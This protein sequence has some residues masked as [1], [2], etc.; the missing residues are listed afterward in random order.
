MKDTAQRS[1]LSIVFLALALVVIVACG[2]QVSSPSNSLTGRWISTDQIYYA[3]DGSIDPSQLKITLTYE[4]SEDGTFFRSHTIVH[5]DVIFR[6]TYS[7]I[8][9]KIVFD[10]L[11]QEV[12]EEIRDNLSHITQY[13][14]EFV[15]SAD[16]LTLTTPSSEQFS[17]IETLYDKVQ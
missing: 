12:P 6:G 13:E 11:E 17:K 7:V 3:L 14:N 9:N 16:T 4:F 2:T 10:V 8:N 1:T 15:L 5:G